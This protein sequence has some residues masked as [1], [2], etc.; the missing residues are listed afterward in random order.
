MGLF[1]GWVQSQVSFLL[2]DG[3]VMVIT[4]LL[5]DFSYGILVTGLEDN[6]FQDYFRILVTGL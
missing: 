3:K 6:L 1:W 4:G 5:Q 2:E